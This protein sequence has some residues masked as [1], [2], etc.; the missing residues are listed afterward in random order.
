MSTD[1]GQ[2]E[3]SEPQPE[4]DLPQVADLR[5]RRV[6]LE[7]AQRR[8]FTSALPRL[9]STVEFV[10][11][12]D[13]PIPVRALAPVLYVGETPVTE[14]SADDATRYRFVALHPDALEPGAP[15][16]L[17]WSGRPIAESVQTDFRFEKPADLTAESSPGS[18]T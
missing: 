9:D 14:V 4:F 13:A 7:P 10:V 17:G 18:E 11:E 1:A 15:I 16:R 6:P 2:L 12:T 3:P 8:N 5:V